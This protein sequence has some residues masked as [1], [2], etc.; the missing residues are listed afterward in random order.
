MSLNYGK[1]R[2]IEI[3]IH[4]TILPCTLDLDSNYWVLEEIRNA[5]G[6]GISDRSD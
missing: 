6:R 4:T 2:K 5:Q 1:H 3:H